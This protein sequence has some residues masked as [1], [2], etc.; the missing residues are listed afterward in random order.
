MRAIALGDL[1]GAEQGQRAGER[2]RALALLRR[3]SIVHRLLYRR[4][5]DV[6]RPQHQGRDAV[7]QRREGFAEAAANASSRGV[8][9]AAVPA[10]ALA[11][12]SY[13]ILVALP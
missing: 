3:Q 13:R 10:L 5:I 9:A 1:I 4:Q 2:D 6:E 7:V 12:I 8:P 11:K